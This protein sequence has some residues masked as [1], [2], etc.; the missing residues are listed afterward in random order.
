MNQVRRLRGSISPETGRR[1]PTSMLLEIY[2]LPRST[3]YDGVQSATVDSKQKA[4]PGKRGPKTQHS[5]EEMT[6]MIRKVIA[7]SPFSGEGH[8]KVR[9][10][11]IMNGVHVGKNRILRLMNENGLLAPSRSRHEAVK[12]VHDGRITTD[13]P[14]VCWGGDIT[15]VMTTDDGKV[16]IIDI[17]DHCTDEVL[18]AH[19]VTSATR[20]EAVECLHQAIHK[21]FGAVGKD[22]AR[23][24]MLRIDHGS[25]FTSKRYTNEGRFLGIDLSYSFVGQPQCNGVIERWH[26]TLKEQLLWTRTWRNL[27][28]VRQAVREFVVLYN[29]RWLIERHGFLSPVEFKKRFAN[30]KEVA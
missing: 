25:Q 16:S 18:A 12:R 26:R 30:R 11:I 29:Q 13:R 21:E 3:F 23:G 19:V 4:I 20:F 6:E 27:A 22:V 28:E 24:V 8:R 17:M 5:D 1:Y 7:E 14:N 9:A 10:R 2:Q 15:E